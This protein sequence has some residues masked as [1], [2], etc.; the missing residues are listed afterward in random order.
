MLLGAR[1]T[2]DAGK[3]GKG[4]LGLAYQ[5]EFDGEARAH[6]QIYDIPSPTAQG[7]SVRFEAG[8]T[9]QQTPTTPLAL[10]LGISGSAG[11]QRGIGF[12]AGV[13]YAF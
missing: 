13:N 8:W 7:S 5:Y 3:S 12:H 4:Y 6:W 1:Y 11:K 9:Y 10:D 2:Y